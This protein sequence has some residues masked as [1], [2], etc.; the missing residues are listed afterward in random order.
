MLF[1]EFLS[2]FTSWLLI[3]AAHDID[4]VM[5]SG[6]TTGEGMNLTKRSFL[7]VSAAMAALV[8]VLVA[9]APS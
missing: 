4:M 8:G 3:G 6:A 2:N 7:A 9:A 5:Q 1:V